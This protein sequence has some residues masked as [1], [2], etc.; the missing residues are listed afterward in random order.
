MSEK[1]CL[2]WNDF[3]EN[4]TN[5]FGGLR[6]DSDFADVTL[7]CEDGK[8]F[9]AHKVILA[10]S[11]P[12][13]Q[14]LLKKNNHAHPLIYMRGL[15]SEDLEAMIDFLYCGEA[16]V[17]QENLDSFLAIAE[18]L[19][20][21]GLMGKTNED[22]LEQRKTSEQKKAQLPKN[23]S[24]FS[25]VAVEPSQAQNDNQI[26][27]T[28]HGTSFG[29]MAQT[30]NFSGDLQEL[31]NQTTSMMLKTSRKSTTGNTFYKC[32][33]CGKE[34]EKTN[35]KNHIEANHLEGISIPCIQCGKTFRSRRTLAYHKHLHHNRNPSTHFNVLL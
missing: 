2:Q 4:V 18:E 21:K 15:K 30:S 7:A 11:S 26:V 32:T 10:A 20:L 22:D 17:Y 24:N 19:K 25:K 27:A 5:A 1:L 28:D 31:D 6:K 29:T 14:N 35:L 12:L 23:E 8:Q 9:E 34:A 3:K 16:N 13:F 33:L